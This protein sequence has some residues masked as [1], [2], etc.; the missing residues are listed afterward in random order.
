MSVLGL[1]IP[2]VYRKL[3]KKTLKFIIT[4]IIIGTLILIID[5]CF[6]GSLKRYS[7]EFAWLFII[8]IALLT[9]HCLSKK[10][11]I[12]I[13]LVFFSCL[14][15]FFVIFDGKNDDLTNLREPK[16]Y[17]DLKYSLMP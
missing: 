3:D 6:G 12:L 10:K 2:F 14:I 5:N 8:P 17:Y 16:F 9:I 7:L 11:K 13:I 4:F 15:N 1:I